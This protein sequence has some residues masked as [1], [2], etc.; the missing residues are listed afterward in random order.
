MRCTARS[1]PEGWKNGAEEGKE[2]WGNPY[3]LALRAAGFHPEWIEPLNFQPTQM[4]HRLRRYCQPALHSPR[5]VASLTAIATSKVVG[6]VYEDGG[7]S[8]AKRYPCQ[9]GPYPMHRRHAGPRK[10]QLSDRDQ[11]S[12][13]TNHADHG[14]RRDLAG[15]RVLLV[16]ID[17]SSE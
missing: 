1:I 3:L 11:T 9:D 6:C 13:D 4:R 5:Q 14:F 2:N 12:T 10:P 8:C 17:H 16:R 7:V 15:L